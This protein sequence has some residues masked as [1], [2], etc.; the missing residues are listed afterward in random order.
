MKHVPEGIP[1]TPHL[2]IKITGGHRHAATVDDMLGTFDKLRGEI[3]IPDA[4]HKRSQQ[5]EVPRTTIG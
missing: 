4:L 1:V 5:I 2:F 3:F